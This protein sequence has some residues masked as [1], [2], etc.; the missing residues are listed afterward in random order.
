MLIAQVSFIAILNDHI[1]LSAPKLHLRITSKREFLPS[2][3][4]SIMQHVL[5]LLYPATTEH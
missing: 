2:S 4:S 3:G 1:Q 5:Q